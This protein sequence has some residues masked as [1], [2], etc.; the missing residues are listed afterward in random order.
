NKAIAIQSGMTDSII[1]RFASAQGIEDTL[2]RTPALLCQTDELDTIFRSMKTSEGSLFEAM[3]AMLLTLVGE[4]S[5][6]HVMRVKAGETAS[7]MISQPHVCIFGTAIRAHFYD[8]LSDRMMTNGL[9]SR[10]IVLDCETKR[11]GQDAQI[12]DPLPERVMETAKWWTTFC[13]GGD[14][15]VVTPEPVTVPMTPEA[16][17]LLSKLRTTSDRA[18]TDA[19]PNDELSRVVWSRVN[20]HARKLALVYAASVNREH[21]VIDIAA[22]TWGAAFA[23]HQAVRMLSMIARFGNNSEFEK[24]CQ[25]ILSRLNAAPGRRLQ[26]GPLLRKMKN[27]SSKLFDERTRTMLERGDIEI[28]HTA[29]T[30]GRPGTYYVAR[31]RGVERK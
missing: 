4:S 9:L 25:D 26:R 20:E 14:M 24:E 29:N 8:S 10:L 28:E 16:R 27:L 19:A 11:I 21:P 7:G 5:S 17:L 18:Y 22:A 23:R 6:T 15:A 1:D 30:G 3:Q 13:P 12:I 31:R 2:L